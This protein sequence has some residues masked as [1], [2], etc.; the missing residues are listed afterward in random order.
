MNAH[1]ERVFLFLTENI[2]LHIHL[3]YFLIGA[4]S[5]KE[6]IEMQRGFFYTLNWAQFVQID[7][8]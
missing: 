6:V 5:E 8:Y 2:E 1:L 7:Q 3:N 4:A